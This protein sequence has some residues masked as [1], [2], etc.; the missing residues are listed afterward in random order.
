VIKHQFPALGGWFE[1]L[2]DVRKFGHYSLSNLLLQGLFLFICQEKSRNAMNNRIEESDC[3]RENFSRLFKGMK[4][5]HFDTVDEVLRKIG[6]EDLEKVKVKMIRRLIEK[7][8]LIKYNGYYLVTV[9][10]TGVTSYDEDPESVL[11]HKTSKNGKVTYL[12]I[13]L[14]AKLVTPEGLCLSLASEPL[15]NEEIAEYDK[16]DCETKAFKRLAKKIKSFY[17]R[18]PVCILADAFYANQSLFEICRDNEWQFIVTFKDKQLKT[19]QTEIS[20]LAESVRIR[21]EKQHLVNKKLHRYNIQSYQAIEG[22]TY[23]DYRLNW[24]ECIELQPSTA[25]PAANKKV[26]TPVKFVYLT[27]ISLGEIA[28]LKEDR[29]VKIVKAGR[30]RWKTENEGFNTQKNLGY[31]LHHKFAR[32]AVK[33]LHNY[34]QLLQMAHIINQLVIHSQA[35]ALW[36]KQKSRRTV[37][38]LWDMMQAVLGL[39]LLSQATLDANEGRYQI[40]YD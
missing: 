23:L 30:Y 13:M 10:A 35:V 38:F 14:E 20:D 29:I 25:Q 27:N 19:L 40:R 12:N 2:P 26:P 7:K 16:Q 15:S 3:Y 28:D 6:M 22:L 31:H 33:T 5:A 24:I 18:L 21:F 34:Y 37:D 32:N 1:T 9:D 36:L 8:V 4:T 39:K 11:L 17:P